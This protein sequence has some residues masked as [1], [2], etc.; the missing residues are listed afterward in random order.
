[1]ST[2][3]GE[4]SHNKIIHIKEEITIPDKSNNSINS[5]FGV[6]PEDSPPSGDLQHKLRTPEAR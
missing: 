4:E 6:A 3:D 5:P 1:M 2:N